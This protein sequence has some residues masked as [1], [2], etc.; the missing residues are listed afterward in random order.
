MS[1][2]IFMVASITRK[3]LALSRGFSIRN[4]DRRWLAHF[5]AHEPKHHLRPVRHRLACVLPEDTPGLLNWVGANEARR[6][7]VLPKAVARMIERLGS[8]AARHH[9]HLVVC[10]DSVERDGGIYNT[11]PSTPIFYLNSGPSK[12]RL[13]FDNPKFPCFWRSGISLVI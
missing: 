7:D 5:V 11:A 6:K 1:G 2:L 10:S 12:P 3:T 8:A 9:M 4:V 13:A